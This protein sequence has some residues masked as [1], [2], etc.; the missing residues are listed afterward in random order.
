MLA[1]TAP[2]RR[3]AHA[4]PGGDTFVVHA[5]S[6][7]VTLPSPLLR[8]ARRRRRAARTA[9]APRPRRAPRRAHPSTA[10]GLGLGGAASPAPSHTEQVGHGV[11]AGTLY[12]ADAG[13]S[14]LPLSRLSLTPYRL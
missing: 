11:Y 2:Y 12:V 3:C 9:T 10:E 13:E 4:R 14:L 7:D 5:A 6:A 8:E 1:A